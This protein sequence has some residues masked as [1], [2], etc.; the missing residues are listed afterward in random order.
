MGIFFGGEEEDDKVCLA[1]PRGKNRAL[2]WSMFELRYK[3]VFFS[4]NRFQPGVAEEVVV[5]VQ[6]QD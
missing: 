5:G 4:S 1:T 2:N 6:E 3:S